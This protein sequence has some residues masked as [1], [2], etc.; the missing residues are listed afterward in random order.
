MSVGVAAST[1]ATPLAK[2]FAGL[3]RYVVNYD[4]GTNDPHLLNV[5]GEAINAGIHQMNTRIWKWSMTRQAITTVA[6]DPDYSLNA[7]YHKPRTLFRV[8]TDGNRE[9][10]LSWLD[11]KS[12]YDEHTWSNTGGTPGV[13]TVD[14]PL[15][16]RLLLLNYAP[17]SD[18]V[19]SYPTLHFY[20]LPRITLLSSD[21]D[22][23]D[24]IKVPPEVW[25]LLG[26][27]ARWDFAMS[28]DQSV[29]KID[30]ADR[31]WRDLF[32]RLET[33]DN[34]EYTDWEV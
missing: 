24:T 22:T 33:D 27:Y 30:R 9:G 23:M 34:D 4:Q 13:Y 19:A 6:S 15:Q 31:M 29:S 32:K 14:R 11:P 18:W 1:A 8:N 10:R 26:W 5:A 16:T 17:T 20:Y 12:F 25:L 28:R 2:N 21:S 3:K 7:D